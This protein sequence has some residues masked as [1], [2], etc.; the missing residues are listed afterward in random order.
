MFS[1]FQGFYLFKR[2]KLSN[3]YFRPRFQTHSILEKLAKENESCC[4]AAAASLLLLR[5]AEGE[6]PVSPGPR[7]GTKPKAH[8]ERSRRESELEPLPRRFRGF[9]THYRFFNI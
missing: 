2:F 5:A 8:R 4:V 7:P 9:L 3:Q 6:G 1:C